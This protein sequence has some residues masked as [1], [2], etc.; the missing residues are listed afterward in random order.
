MDAY[1]LIHS[2]VTRIP[3]DLAPFPL[4]SPFWVPFNPGLLG[5]SMFLL[6]FYSAHA[7]EKIFFAILS[8]ASEVGSPV[9]FPLGLAVGTHKVIHCLPSGSVEP[10]RGARS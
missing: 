10:M 7:L 3:C 5:C 2:I 8:H 9:N 6:D 4:R 1:P